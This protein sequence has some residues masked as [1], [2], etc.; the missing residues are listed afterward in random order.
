[1]KK[2][3]TW[4]LMLSLSVFAIGCG[5]DKAGTD[6]EDSDNTEGGAAAGAEEPG[7]HTDGEAE[8]NEGDKPGPDATDADDVEGDTPPDGD[9]K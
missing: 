4:M 6:A 1:M 2:L 5:G 3:A 8:G 9:T 7:E